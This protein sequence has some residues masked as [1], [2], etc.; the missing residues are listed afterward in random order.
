MKVIATS[1]TVFAIAFVVL[2]MGA[3]A[4]PATDAQAYSP[5]PPEERSDEQPPR[6][7]LL[8]GTVVGPNG[9]AIDDADVEVRDLWISEDG[10]RKGQA[11]YET[12]TDE[13][14]AFEINV[15]EGPIGLQIDKFGHQTANLDVEIS[16]DTAIEVPLPEVTGP[17]VQIH[18]TVADE[19]GPPVEDARV[20][21]DR[22]PN[23]YEA[24]DERGH[25][26]ESTKHVRES[27]DDES[28]A[29]VDGEPHRVH[30]DGLD[31]YARTQTDQNGEYELLMRPGNIEVDA[32]RDGYLRAETQVDATTPDEQVD[33]ELTEIPPNSVTV[34]GTVT[35]ENADPIEDAQ[36]NVANQAWGHHANVRTDEDGTYEVETKP[37][38]TLVRVSADETYY[39]PC[40]NPRHD[41]AKQ[42]EED[43]GR[44]TREQ[45][46]LS[47]ASSMIAEADETVTHD[48]SL[49][50]AP[51]PDAR[52]EGWV[53]NASSGEAIPNATVSVHNQ[54]TNEHGRAET[55]EDGSYAIPV[56]AGYYTIRVHA[57]GHYPNA[58]NAQVDADETGQVTLQVEPGQARHSCC[59]AYAEEHK[60]SRDAA[61]SD[62]GHAPESDDSAGV[63][64]SASSSEN[65][66]TFEGG[67]G[68]LGTYEA[69]TASNES[70]DHA[71]D[72]PRGSPAPSILL[73]IA[74]VGSGA[75]AIKVWDRDAYGP[76]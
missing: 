73:T 57:P 32:Y 37:G 14:G 17:V 28:Q 1:R 9:T 71:I 63:S 74:L 43:C 66:A 58:T 34:T 39:L 53:V 5:A 2:A 49:P 46:Y 61:G 60:A 30:Y 36:V 47:A 10:D 65:E 62:G 50:A 55:G 21:A 27:P 20:A 48:V 70:G 29:L 16:N 72:E 3:V 45:G 8:E 25:V 12:T 59:Y 40:E 11:R 26:C 64:E 52:L 38:Y 22:S 18:G 19:E 54:V 44:Q 33:L 67:P 15:S 76:R 35:D 69:D 31:D 6:E 56:R 41:D 75:L 7:L 23:C 4:Q 42:D 24:E 13:N 68:N 51:S